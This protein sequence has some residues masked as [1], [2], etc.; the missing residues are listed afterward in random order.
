VTGRAVV[1]KVRTGSVSRAEAGEE[2]SPS[3]VTLS[4]EAS[5]R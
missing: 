2:H 4:N 3:S 1:S 5:P